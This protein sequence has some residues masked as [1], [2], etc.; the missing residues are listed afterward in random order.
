[1]TIETG[2]SPFRAALKDL[3]RNLKQFGAIG[4]NDVD[5]EAL[6]KSLNELSRT[7][8]KFVR[9]LFASMEAFDVDSREI[10]K[11]Q[12]FLNQLKV[13]KDAQNKIADNMENN[14][15]LLS[16]GG[17]DSG[18]VMNTMHTLL[19]NQIAV[20]DKELKIDY[21]ETLRSEY[22][23]NNGRIG[24]IEKSKMCVTGGM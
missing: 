13:L 4:S 18:A 3:Q 19:S 14:I 12:D 6:V 17:A 2:G 11:G 15:R 23:R 10:V 22:F 24:T 20:F 8:E 5:T 16:A 1:E 7:E 21:F 9:E